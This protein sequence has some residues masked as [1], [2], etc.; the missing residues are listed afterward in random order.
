M[1]LSVNVENF[2]MNYF[3]YLD[4]KIDEY[5]NELSEKAKRLPLLKMVGVMYLIFMTFMLASLVI[6]W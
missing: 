6:Q 5:V 3:R 1:F 2:K 4:L